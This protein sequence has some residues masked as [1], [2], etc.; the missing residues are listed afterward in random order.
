MVACSTSSPSPAYEVAAAEKFSG[1]TTIAA[2]RPDAR[3]LVAVSSSASTQEKFSSRSEST[4][5]AVI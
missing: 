1:M 2:K 4:R 3:P 5:A